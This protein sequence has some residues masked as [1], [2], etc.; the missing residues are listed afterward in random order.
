MSQFH[1]GQNVLV[2]ATPFGLKNQ[3]AIILT[4]SEDL[5]TVKSGNLIFVCTAHYLKIPRQTV[6]IVTS[7]DELAGDVIDVFETDDKAKEFILTLTKLQ[8]RFATI[9]SYEV[10]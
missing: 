2:T 9:K 3:P 1:V 4:K 7:H 6:H 5:Y 10:K 8:Q